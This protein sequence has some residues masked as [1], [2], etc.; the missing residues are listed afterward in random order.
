MSGDISFGTFNLY[1]LQLPGE[2]W[3]GH[4]YTEAEYRAK[5]VWS[6]GMLARLD[7]DVIGFQE[8][9]SGRC[10][11]DVFEGAGL[12]D[13][14]ELVFIKPDGEDWYD[15]AVAAAVRRPWRVKNKAVHKTFPDAVR[16][17]KRGRGPQGDPEDNE[18]D[19]RID[20]FAR[21]IIE[22]TVGLDGDDDVPDVRVFFAHLKSK[23]PTNLDREEREDDAVRVH[24]G[25]LGS[26]ISTIRRT[27][28][29]AAL[30]A[31]LT[32]T[33]KHTDM[34]V[35]LVGDLNDAQ[36]SNTLSIISD[37]PPYRLYQD[38]R[39]GFQSDIGLYTAGT[40]Q[41]FR[42]LRDVYYTHIHQGIRE[43]LDHILVSEQFY[44]FSRRRVWS[45]QDMRVWND[46]VE[47]HVD[48]GDTASSD[49]GAV[50]ARFLYDPA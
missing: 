46:H 42:A 12:H 28:E 33:M 41:E 13:D 14:Y 44:D 40:L 36:L 30:R 31:L 19:V 24:A 11:H 16:L 15:I 38:S 47:D 39:V 10:L 6:A 35:V 26:A 9:W 34:P 1:N 37:Q 20:I 49:H 29:A 32:D 48:D 22:L 43:T 27:A 18:I 25:A 8:L 4:T 17:I 45:F 21:S 23:V 7:A 5:I 3:R 50:A 2:N